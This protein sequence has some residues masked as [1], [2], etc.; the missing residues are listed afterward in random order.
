MGGGRH[1]D[2]PAKLGRGDPRDGGGKRH[3][4]RRQ[5]GRRYG[6]SEGKRR[7]S[8]IEFGNQPGRPE[9]QD[10]EMNMLKIL[11]WLI[12]IKLTISVP[13]NFACLVREMGE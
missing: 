2:R 6:G 13:W 11:L 10:K 12:A 7:R 1:G 5:A 8:W 3:G 9:R 4:T